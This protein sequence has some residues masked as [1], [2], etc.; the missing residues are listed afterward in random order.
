MPPGKSI[1]DQQNNNYT[2]QLATV[3]FHQVMQVGKKDMG[4]NTG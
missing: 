3:W 2:T 1:P 4:Q